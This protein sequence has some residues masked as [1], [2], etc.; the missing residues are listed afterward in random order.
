MVLESFIQDNDSQ[1]SW[2][3]N[4]HVINFSS[5]FKQHVRIGRV[6]ESELRVN[7]ISMS[8]LHCYIK[9]DNDGSFYIEDNLSKFGTLV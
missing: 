2:Q 6:K 5:D 4:I 7:D 1:Q 3:K 9:K 8:R